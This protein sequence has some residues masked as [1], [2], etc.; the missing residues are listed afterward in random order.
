[1]NTSIFIVIPSFAVHGGIRVICEWA[2]RL[3]AKYI[4]YLRPLKGAVGP[5]WFT[6]TN[7][8]QIV[9][10]DSKCESCDLL[11]VTSPHCWRYLNQP[12]PTRKVIFLQ[13]LEEK[14][15]P[16]DGMWRASCC[17]LYTSAHPLITISQ[18]G[19]DH[20]KKEWGRTG[21][22]YYV[23][24]GVN[25]D[26]FPI[27]DGRK[28]PKTL[29]V[30]GWTPLNDTK[31]VDRIG[32]RAAA[33][34]KG[35]GWKVL[36]YSSRPAS[37]LYANLADEYYVCPDLE[38]LNSLY[39]RASILLKATRY[40]FRSCAPMEAMTKGTVTVRACYKGD[41]DL[42]NGDNCLRC[43]YELASFT[44]LA[45]R[46]AGDHLLWSKLSQACLKYVRLYDWDY[47]MQRID[48]VLWK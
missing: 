41:D 5:G 32:P 17:R 16:R 4:V 9:L 6:F 28:E 7:P 24:N 36:A 2:N 23:G 22:T 46:L 19:I 25:F 8:V 12:L 30:E 1:M 45:F 14:F 38:V 21:P 39:R 29:L 43:S 33:R 47:W 48:E 10:D 44:S 15:R 20:I 13:M 18:W 3:A 27:E 37:G 42:V 26:H 40:D 34:M 31:D 11:I 35:Q